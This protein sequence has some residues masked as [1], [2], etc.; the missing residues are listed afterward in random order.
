MT[1]RKKGVKP[2]ANGLGAE[3]PRAPASQ[4][5]PEV[6]CSSATERL[7]QEADALT[8]TQRDAIANGAELRQ[9]LVWLD[10]EMTG[11]PF[12]QVLQHW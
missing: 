8:L 10:M 9:P 4:Q 7:A 12:A 5:T 1:H 2:T 6:Q 11:M 3:L